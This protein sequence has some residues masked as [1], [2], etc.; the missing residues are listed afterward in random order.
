M[1]GWIKLHRKLRHN[2]IWQDPYYLKLWMYC[3]TEASHKEHTQLVGTKTVKLLPGQFV[4]GRISLAEELNKGMTPKK[5]KSE[6]TWWRYLIQLENMQM[7]NIESNNKHSVVT[8]VNWEFYQ[9][10]EEKRTGEW[11][12]SEQ[13][14]NSKWTTD[15]QQMN[16]NKNVKNVRTKEFS[17]SSGVVDSK[18]AEVIEFYQAN[19]QKGIFE[20][21]H[22]NQLL[23]QFYEEWGAELL[24]AAMK[25]TAEKEI[26]GVTY[27]EGIL[28]NWKVAGIKTVEQARQYEKEFRSKNNV[29]H[30]RSRKVAGEIDW[31]SL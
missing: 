15:E 29:R 13:Q 20:T 10:S 19:L 27:L 5:V 16:T 11:T 3:L 1:Q 26:K 7:L 21:P 24:L 12:A 14:V 31:E 2:P 23:T 9:D 22:N 25:L 18:F 4:V 30:F 28:K 17:S 6:S 8:I